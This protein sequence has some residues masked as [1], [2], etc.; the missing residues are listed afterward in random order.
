MLHLDLNPQR[1]WSKE[2][3]HFLRDDYEWDWGT[4]EPRGGLLQEARGHTD[5]FHTVGTGLF[6]GCSGNFSRR[7][8]TCPS[9][10]GFFGAWELEPPCQTQGSHSF[11]SADF[12]NYWQVT[13]I[14]SPSL[15]VNAKPCDVH[16]SLM[17]RPLGPSAFPG[18]GRTRADPRTS[19][20]KSTTPPLPVLWKQQQQL[21]LEVRWPKSSVLGFSWSLFLVLLSLNSLNRGRMPSKSPSKCFYCCEQTH[22]WPPT[23]L[24]VC[25]V[26]ASGM[27]ALEVR[28]PSRV[29]SWYD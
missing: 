3:I 16:R 6:L 2:P 26:W 12:W 4:K 10:A 13:R 11:S 15:L 18:L 7:W 22:F 24:T 17:K 5:V 29:F 8:S 19:L 1:C 23:S 9:G 27:E 21:S 14:K 20:L 25:H 28:S